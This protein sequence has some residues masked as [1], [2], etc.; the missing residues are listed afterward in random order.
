MDTEEKFILEEIIMKDNLNKVC[1]KDLEN[2]FGQTVI[3]LLVYGN[4]IKEKDSENI[5]TAQD[6]MKENL[7]KIKEKEMGPSFIKVGQYL[8]AN[9]NK[10]KN[11]E[12]AKLLIKMERSLLKGTG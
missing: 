2:M 11:T 8:K 3:H 7:S 10:I 6:F 5:L 1:Q 9:G 4:K 12:K